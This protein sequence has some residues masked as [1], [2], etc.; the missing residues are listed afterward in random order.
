MFEGFHVVSI[1]ILQDNKAVNRLVDINKI[2][3]TGVSIN[4]QTKKAVSEIFLYLFFILSYYI[5][6]DSL[7]EQTNLKMENSSRQ[8]KCVFHKINSR[9]DVSGIFVH[10]DKMRKVVKDVPLWLFWIILI[11]YLG[12]W[13]YSHHWNGSL[14]SFLS[15]IL[16]F[17]LIFII[18]LTCPVSSVDRALN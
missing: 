1:F 13:V 18:D 15:L 14:G 9:G 4:K 5:I 12:L 3:R 11:I 8:S 7:V 17:R 6:W 2:N 16:L 10:V